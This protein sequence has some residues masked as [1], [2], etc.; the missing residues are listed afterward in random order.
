MAQYSIVRKR[1]ETLLKF[2]LEDPSLQRAVPMSTILRNFGALLSAGRIPTWNEGA[3]ASDFYGLS[4]EAKEFDCFI[5]HSWSASRAH[6][7]VALAWSTNLGPALSAAAFGAVA[8]SLFSWSDPYEV[9][10]TCDGVVERVGITFVLFYFMFVVLLALAHNVVR[11]CQDDACFFDKGCIDQAHGPVKQAQIDSLGAF[12]QNSRRMIVLWS[13]DYFHRLWCT[14][15]LA[16]YIHLNDGKASAIDLVPLYLPAFALT[17]LTAVTASLAMFLCFY[18]KDA[19]LSRE[20]SIAAALVIPYGLLALELVDIVEQRQ[21]LEH[22]IKTYTVAQCQ[23]TS[24]EDRPVVE[25]AIDKLFHDLS[26][27]GI[28]NFEATMRS[29]VAERIDTLLGSN[30]FPAPLWTQSICTLPFFFFGLD[31]I[32]MAK[33]AGVADKASVY[34]DVA[35][36]MLGPALVLPTIVAIITSIVQ[37]S[38]KSFTA[39]KLLVKGLAVCSVL[40]LYGGF[41]AGWGAFVRN[42]GTT[43]VHHA[44]VAVCSLLILTAL[45]SSASCRGP[46]LPRPV[47]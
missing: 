3:V 5:S 11:W 8:L 26:Q 10:T 24:E 17:Y 34:E 6:K 4:S 29:E 28:P 46:P 16:A 9:L 30:A 22:A 44:A 31:A 40:T 12:L 43:P 13:P 7:F 20:T 14:Y 47:A 41:W 42:P 27:D 33:T 38:L 37:W 23:V 1:T 39:R 32:N 45:R 15:E 35:E 2:D 25:G 19:A 36:Y 21:A 18:T